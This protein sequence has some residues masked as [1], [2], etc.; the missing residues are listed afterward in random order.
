MEDEKPLLQRRTTRTVEPPARWAGAIAAGLTIMAEPEW[1][2]T[3]WDGEPL[4]TLREAADRVGV[5]RKLFPENARAMGMSMEEDCRRRLW[6]ALMSLHRRGLSVQLVHE[7]SPETDD[8]A[9]APA[10]K[11]RKVG[12]TDSPMVSAAYQLTPDDVVLPRGITFLDPTATREIDPGDDLIRQVLVALLDAGVPAY[13]GAVTSN[14]F[15]RGSGRPDTRHKISLMRVGPEFDFEL[16]HIETGFYVDAGVAPQIVRRAHALGLRNDEVARWWSGDDFGLDDAELAAWRE[17][18]GATPA[19]PPAWDDD[20]SHTRGQWRLQFA[21][22]PELMRLYA[23]RRVGRCEHRGVVH[24]DAEREVA[25]AGLA[26]PFVCMSSTDAYHVVHCT[27]AGVERSFSPST[28]D[29]RS[30]QRGTPESAAAFIVAV[31]LGRQALAFF[32]DQADGLRL[33]TAPDAAATQTT[34]DEL[35]TA[36][37]FESERPRITDRAR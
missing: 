23:T 15:T 37:A 21:F 33:S 13:V 2:P 6:A 17:Q 7:G 25:D 11:L 1:E 12:A 24:G 4:L 9:T 28:N 19:W 31:G 5:H 10:V 20:V 32:A 35:L 3:G 8:P 22:P 14:G 36:L 18:H 29:G 26:R 30:P 16:L 34:I 27:A